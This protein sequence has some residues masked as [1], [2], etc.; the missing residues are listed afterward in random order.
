LK[1]L[2]EEMNDVSIGYS[3]DVEF[4]MRQCF[5]SIYE[6]IFEIEELQIDL[7]YPEIIH[8]LIT[9][10]LCTEVAVLTLFFASSNPS[11]RTFLMENDTIN[12]ILNTVN[13]PYDQ[14]IILSQIIGLMTLSNISLD[15]KYTE[16]IISIQNIEEKVGKWIYST[17][18]KKESSQI[19]RFLSV[20]EYVWANLNP[21]IQLLSS[22]IVEFQGWGLIWMFIFM[23]K[24]EEREL[25]RMMGGFSK[26]LLFSWGKNG[27]NRYLARRC[28]E[29]I[30]NERNSPPSLLEL[31]IFKI[32]EEESIKWEHVALLPADLREKYP[33]MGYFK[34][35]KK[36]TLSPGICRGVT[37]LYWNTE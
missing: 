13:A 14:S 32:Q 36:Y 12:M 22:P 26:I 9:T 33:A 34:K 29:L 7:W 30:K 23:S 11:L 19:S 8:T 4:H 15:P 5:L 20:E 31:A 21:F 3:Y 18:F 37:I 27:L 25:L 16:K 1:N 6:N 2:F 17:P 35:K 24:E 10:P 28:L